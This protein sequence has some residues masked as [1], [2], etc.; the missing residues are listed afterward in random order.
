MGLN[1]SRSTRGAFILIGLLA[2]AAIY[3]GWALH[4]A[5]RYNA[6]VERQDWT[7]AA[8]YPR[9]RGKLAAALVYQ[10]K[11]DR[12]AALEVYAEIESG[13]RAELAQISRYNMANL[14]LRQGMEA[15]EAGSMDLALPLIELAK[16][17]YRQ[18]LQAQPQHWDARFN[19]AVALKI[20]PDV[21]LEE[22]IDDVLPERSRR[23]L[24]PLEVRREL[25]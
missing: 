5:T 25:P 11:G 7:A 13:G 6:A 4:R 8:R 14:Y 10:A 21:G 17:S 12:Q 24:V 23:S 22:S 1:F 18:V 15:S 19:L 20:V 3:Q 2:V 9:E 16:A